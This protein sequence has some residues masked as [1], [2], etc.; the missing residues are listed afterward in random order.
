LDALVLLAKRYE[1]NNVAW[2]L[3]TFPGERHI[4]VCYDLACDLHD[5]IGFVYEGKRISEKL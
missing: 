5:S 2:H 3:S 4:E 1:Q